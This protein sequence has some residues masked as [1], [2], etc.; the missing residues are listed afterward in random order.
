MG[1]PASEL[2]RQPL[3]TDETLHQVTTT[4]SFEMQRAQVTQAL[5]TAVMESNPSRFAGPNLPV[6][7]VSWQDAQRFIT[8]LNLLMGA[9][10]YRLPTEAEKA[11]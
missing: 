4:R 5:W 6:E 10:A 9:N 8:R 11:G 3:H 1:S 7:K 2:E